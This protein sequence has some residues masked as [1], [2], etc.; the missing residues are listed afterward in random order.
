M[1][2]KPITLESDTF[3]RLK[4]DLTKAMQCLL[5]NMEK[6]RSDEATLTCKIKISTEEK[7]LGQGDELVPS[8]TH[9]I[10][11][12]V[13]IK[14]ERTGA[15][16]GDYALEKDK[17]GSYALKVYTEQLEMFDDEDADEED[18]DEEDIE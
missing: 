6:Y 12:T 15:L 14:D 5:A 9:K 18:E 7:D 3:R 13:Q 17:T 8:F 10:T 2:I 16:M 4:H 11:S 1:K